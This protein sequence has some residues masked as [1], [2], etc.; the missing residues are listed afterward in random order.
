MVV[1]VLEAGLVHVLMTMGRA[2]MGVLMGVLNMLMQVSV[3]RVDM[4]LAL[5]GVL[6]AVQV[7]MHLSSQ[8]SLLLDST[9]R[10]I[11]AGSYLALCCPHK[12]NGTEDPG[13]AIP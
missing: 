1:V 5:V 7:L 13:P 8:R 6:V 12:A 4:R 10:L 9:E 3:V 2:A 11:P